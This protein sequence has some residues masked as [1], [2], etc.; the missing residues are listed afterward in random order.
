MP[1]AQPK[2]AWITHPACLA[3]EMGVGHPECPAR[4]R[5]IESRLVRSGLMERLQRREA[6]RASRA[7]LLRVHTARHVDDVLAVPACGYRQIDPDTLANCHTAEAALRAAGAVVEAVDAVRAG[8]ATLAFCAVRPPGHHAERDRSMGFCFFDNIAVGVAHALAAGLRRVAVVDF[9]VHYGNG[10]ASI[11]RDDPRVL[12]CNTYQS[13][14]YP[15]WESDAANAHLVDVPLRA[16]TDG[17]MWRAAVERAW[18]P[19]LEAHRPE[20]LC[21]SAG[22]DAHRDDPL[23]HLGLEATDYRWMAVQLKALAARYSDGRIVATLEGGYDLHALAESVEA[24][25]RPF[26][27]E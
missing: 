23:A 16:G 17:A 22:F 10:T 18:F 12:V 3:H 1:A 26:L 11:F 13:P 5:A 27:V 14:L 6:P 9:D 4:L 8:Q 21:V 7:A 15:Y 2:V 20:L 24:F 19:A 25:L